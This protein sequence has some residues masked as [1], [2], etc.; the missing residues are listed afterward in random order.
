LTQY[1]NT[2]LHYY[3]SQAQR[4]NDAQLT[5]TPSGTGKTGGTI[6]EIRTA[7]GGNYKTGNPTWTP[8]PAG[9]PGGKGGGSSLGGGGTSGKTFS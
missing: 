1:Y 3:Q 8:R 2:Q 6:Y 4:T 5:V 9:T 7:G